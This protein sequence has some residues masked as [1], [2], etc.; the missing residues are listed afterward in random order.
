MSV[1][2]EI[3]AYRREPRP[4]AWIARK[5]GSTVPDVKA[6]LRLAGYPVLS[7]EINLDKYD[8]IE[9]LLQEGV[10]VTRI[11]QMLNC[12]HGTIKRWFPDAMGQY[13]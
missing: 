7:R 4:A 1:F 2:E 3:L 11:M 12:H 8:R 5:V 13:K 6:V 9:A 10:G